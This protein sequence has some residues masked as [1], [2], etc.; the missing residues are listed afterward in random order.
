MSSAA[1]TEDPNTTANQALPMAAAASEEH[2]TPAARSNPSH[3]P[4]DGGS[5]NSSAS[6]TARKGIAFQPKLNMRP[7]HTP[8]NL[9]VCGGSSTGK[10]SL[11]RMCAEMLSSS[12][13]SAAPSPHGPH[14]AQAAATNSSSVEIGTASG[15]GN[16]AAPCPVAEAAGISQAVDPHAVLLSG[17]DAFTTVLPPILCPEACRELVYTFQVSILC[18]MHGGLVPLYALHVVTG[19]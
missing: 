13:G 6:F 10:T 11:I 2:D 7:I 8:I 1:V 12:E 18:T 14:A 4:L 19:A 16:A 9:L 5:K 15:C 17:A 3:E